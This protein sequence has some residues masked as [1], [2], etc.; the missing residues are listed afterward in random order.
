MAIAARNGVAERIGV[1]ATVP[2]AAGPPDLQ[3]GMM[4]RGAESGLEDVIGW[5]TLRS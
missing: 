2:A 4:D 5:P 1:S 3:A